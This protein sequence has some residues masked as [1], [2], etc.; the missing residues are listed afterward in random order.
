LS[1]VEIYRQLIMPDRLF[2]AS[3]VES[4]ELDA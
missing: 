4:E 1:D 3:T 2:T